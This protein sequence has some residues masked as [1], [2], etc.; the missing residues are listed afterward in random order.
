MFRFLNQ[1]FRTEIETETEIAIA[2]I[3]LGT[4]FFNGQVAN[5]RTPKVS[6]L[7]NRMTISCIV[8]IGDSGGSAG[9]SQHLV[10]QT[11]LLIPTLTILDF[12]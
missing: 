2:E 7:F 10:A 12:L 9:V 1:F 4:E 6:A 8:C 11:P 3:F 5:H